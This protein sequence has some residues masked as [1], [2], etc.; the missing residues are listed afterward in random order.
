MATMQD[1]NSKYSSWTRLK[2]QIWMETAKYVSLHPKM[3][4]LRSRSKMF[5]RN[6][7][8]AT[9]E[10]SPSVIV[11]HSGHHGP[12]SLSGGPI[13]SIN[14]SLW[15]SLNGPGRWSQLFG[16][17]KEF[18]GSEW[19]RKIIRVV[20]QVSASRGWFCF[21]FTTV[22]LKKGHQVCC[23]S[24]A[25][26]AVPWLADPHEMGSWPSPNIRISW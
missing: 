9:P 20:G 22:F 6:K 17:S 26:V 21:S 1:L 24:W 14:Q 3:K 5:A 11:R 10:E 4:T 16:W 13:K 7:Q 8:G 2:P 12:D 19:F 23:Q 25:M 15:P 18:H